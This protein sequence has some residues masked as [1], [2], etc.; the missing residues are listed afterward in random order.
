[1]NTKDHF[2]GILVP[3]RIFVGQSGPVCRW[4]GG[5]GGEQMKSVKTNFT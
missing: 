5:V 2:R 1:M 3:T 4:G